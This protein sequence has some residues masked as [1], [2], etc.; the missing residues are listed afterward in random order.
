MTREEEERQLR[1][2]AGADELAEKLDAYLQRRQAEDRNQLIGRSYDPLANPDDARSRDETIERIDREFDQDERALVVQD[3]QERK[4]FDDWMSQQRGELRLQDAA[5]VQ[6]QDAQQPHLTGDDWT[7]HKQA[8]EWEFSER[9]R[10]R[11]TVEIG[12]RDQFREYQDQ[13][14]YD[15][16]V[17]LNDRHD[18]NLEPFRAS[19]QQEREREKADFETPLPWE[20]PASAQASAAHYMQHRGAQ[21]TPERDFDR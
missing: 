11:D 15:R 18:D 3:L 6:Q 12:L 16:L 4:N 21:K 2:R 1:H 14:H 9:E 8:Q 13:T 17:S 20:T 10:A 5:A 7:R 19:Q